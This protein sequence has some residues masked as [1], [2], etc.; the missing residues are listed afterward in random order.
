M[1]KFPTYKEFSRFN[2][3]C[4]LKV[5]KKPRNPKWIKVIYYP[6]ALVLYAMIYSVIMGMI[7]GPSRPSY[8]TSDKYRKVIKQGILWDSIEYHER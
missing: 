5:N 3:W 4:R 7:K 6:F 8:K 2:D 1:E